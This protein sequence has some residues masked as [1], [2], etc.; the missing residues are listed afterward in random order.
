MSDE[1]YTV[2]DGVKTD[3]PLHDDILDNEAADLA[4]RI[5]TARRAIA[6]GVSENDARSLYGI[7]AEVML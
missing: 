4:N 1:F 5:G 6:D 7:P 2:V 3:A